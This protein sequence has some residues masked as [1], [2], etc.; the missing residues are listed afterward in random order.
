MTQPNRPYP[1]KPEITAD[2]VRGYLH[3][4]AYMLMIYECRV[5]GGREFIWNSRDG[6]TPFG[7][8]CRNAAC[9]EQEMGSPMLHIAWQ[10]D[11]RL[12]AF[13]PW[14]GMRIFRDGTLEEARAIMRRRIESCRGT[15]YACSPEQA[16]E[17]LARVSD[18]DGEFRRGWPMVEEVA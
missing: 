18:Q 4:E 2:G 13:T 12:P 5:C 7:I 6:V 14:R 16:E 17:L 10:A 11:K 9:N 3:G 15:E 1:A 8:S